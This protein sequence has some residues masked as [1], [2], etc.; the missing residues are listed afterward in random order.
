MAGSGGCLS[1][2]K[3][4]V[5][6]RGDLASGRLRAHLGIHPIGHQADIARRRGTPVE[7]ASVGMDLR[8]ASPDFAQLARS[9][10][11]F[12]EGPIEDPRNCRSEVG[13]VCTLGHGHAVLMTKYPASGHVAQADVR[14]QP[15]SSWSQAPLAPFHSHRKT[16]FAHPV[17]C[18]LTAYCAVPVSPSPWS[19]SPVTA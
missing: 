6:N 11:C 14:A 5:E 16:R 8:G 15:L 4:D 1:E 18:N 10:S 2:Q 12:G 7:R 9:M 13:K 3:A 17:W 19:R